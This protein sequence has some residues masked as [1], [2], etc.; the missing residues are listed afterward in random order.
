MENN[1]PLIVNIKRYSLDDGPGI[2]SVVFFKGCP[3]SCI[4]CHNPETQDPKIEIA[5]S[6]VNCLH[7]H[8]CVDVCPENAIDLHL[9]GRIHR[10]ICKRCGSCAAACPG[11]G[12][13]TIGTCYPV[14]R[15]VEILLRDM[16]FYRYSGGGVTLS[17]GECT[18]YPEYVATL[19]K[20]LKKEDIHVSIQTSGYFEYESFREKILPNVD[21]IFFDV[22]I[23][24]PDLHM[25]LTGRSNQRIISNLKRLIGESDTKVHPRV[26]IIPGITSNPENLANIVK[27]LMDAGAEDISLL[28]YNPMGFG[29]TEKIGKPLPALPLHFMPPREEKEIYI[30]VEN[31]VS[32]HRD[33]HKSVGKGLEK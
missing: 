25:K 16:S 32:E 2:R 28:P 17:G 9:A 21:L 4:F 5:F 33:C 10:Q 1:T 30:M 26:P 27:I 14:D 31:L 7:C 8:H 3:L 22:K 23:A 11:S 12:L 15:L 6:A 29:L 20:H 19:L 18:L 13:Q 24:D